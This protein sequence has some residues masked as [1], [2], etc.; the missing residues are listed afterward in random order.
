M[1]TKKHLRLP[2]NKLISN[3]NTYHDNNYIAYFFHRD[4]EVTVQIRLDLHKGIQQNQAGKT[5]CREQNKSES[6][7]W[8]GKETQKVAKNEQEQGASDKAS[9][10][11]RTQV[12]E[13]Q[14][15]R[16]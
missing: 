16:V 9:K 15:K 5:E 2:F 7:T 4:A 10:E 14:E 1:R 6:R 11:S 8:V 3:Y 12:T 13:N